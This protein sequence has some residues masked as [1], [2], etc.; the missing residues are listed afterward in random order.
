MT[1]PLT[2]ESARVLLRTIQADA[3]TKI[4]QVGGRVWSRIGDD[5]DGVALIIKV[6]VPKGTQTEITEFDA[7]EE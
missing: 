2:K 7:P 3:K 1:E 6:E 4:E 5:N